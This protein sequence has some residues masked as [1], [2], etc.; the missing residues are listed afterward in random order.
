LASPATRPPA[1]EGKHAPA[2]ETVAILDFG[3]QYTQLIA[4][5][6]RELGVY[7]EI[8]PHDVSAETIRARDDRALILSG[9]PASVTSPDSPACDRALYRLGIPVLGICYGMQ[10]MA[11]DL[12]GA[13]TRGARREYGHARL[14]LRRKGLLFRGVPERTRVWMSHGD[15]VGAPPPGF[16]TLA[17]T[18]TVPVAAMADP[19]RRLYGV[20]FHPEV[21]HTAR[22]RDIL[23]NFLFRVARCAG[24]WTMKSFVETTVR[25]LRERVGA[26]RVLCAVSGGVDSSVLAA[27]L[28]RA[29]RDRLTCVFINNGLLRKEEHRRV[30][31]LFREQMGITVHVVNAA[32]EFIRRLRGVTSPERKR[33]IIGGTFIRVFER[34]TRRLGAFRFL[35]QGTLYPDVIESRSPTGGP[36]ATIKTHHNVGGLPRRM[37]FE[38]I[39]PLRYLFKDEVRRIGKELGLPDAVVWRHPFPG[40]GLAVRVVGAVTRARLRTLREADAIV[41]EELRRS[42]Q[43][44]RTWQ[45]FAVLLPVKAVGVM[46]DE[47]TY[48]NVIA[49]RAVTSRD[50]M[51]ADWARLPHDVLSVISNRII[52]EVK[53][54]N[55]V[56]YDVSS[57]PPSTIEWE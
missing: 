23:A 11:R 45:A 14:R 2:A 35:A 41:R 13:L 26:D 46:G 10:L 6:V 24:R 57:K 43:E 50:G 25:R 28:H 9:G 42:G 53:G 5:S 17:A 20:Q 36:S 12:G 52:N 18:G 33:R 48:A 15:S 37:N 51:T 1:V 54:V 39:E 27:L 29:V 30:P 19:E 8:L 44:G 32:D 55:R 4:R 21:A 3:S 34:E 38:L 49:V 22:G 47:R 31:R 7:S 56:V 16:R 40:P